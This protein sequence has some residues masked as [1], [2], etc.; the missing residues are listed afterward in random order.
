M[1]TTI[2]NNLRMTAVAIVS[3]SEVFICVIGVVGYNY[4]TQFIIS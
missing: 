4:I 3:F 1:T 2:K